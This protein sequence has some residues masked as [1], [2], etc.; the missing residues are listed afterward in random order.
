MIKIS[1][2]QKIERSKD[3]KIDVLAAPFTAPA[4]S[5]LME[6]FSSLIGGKPKLKVVP[7]PLAKQAG[8]PNTVGDKEGAAGKEANGHTCNVHK[9]ARCNTICSGI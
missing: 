4:K 2:Y 9:A 6:P 5:N 1:K 7:A 8:C 3:Q